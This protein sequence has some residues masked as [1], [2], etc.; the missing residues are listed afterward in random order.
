MA[1]PDSQAAEIS[2]LNSTIVRSLKSPGLK[3]V[4]AAAG[5][6]GRLSPDL[7]ARLAQRRFFTPPRAPLREAERLILE[8]G[9]QFRI[10]V[11]GRGVVGWRWGE[12]P[13][14]L[15]VHGWGGHAGQM[16]ELVA[17]LVRAGF[18]AVAIDLPGHGASAGSRSSI[19][20]F[21]R[22]IEAAVRYLGGIDVLLA[23]SFGAAG[24]TLALSRG[25]RLRRAVYLAPPAS[26]QRIW[27]RFRAG[28]GIS[29]PV[30][31]RLLRR[32]EL[33]LGVPLNGVEPVLLAPRLEVPLLILHD[34]GDRELPFSEGA[35]LAAAW[36]GAV[37][38]RLEGLGHLRLLKDAATVHEA[39][40]FVA[41]PA[42]RRP[43]I[44]PRAAE[45][46]ALALV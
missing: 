5:A 30:W 29:P 45:A 13:V 42:G 17:P 28:A 35:E 39:V 23:H 10:E 22:A 46:A 26:F 25:L 34:A 27:A 38:R 2:N 24:A 20:H 32:S 37:L 36:P 1:T 12:G 9:R 14:A 41:P 6:L 19:V 18:E 44:A 31:Q 4:R 21:A 3:L 33:W 11:E 43:R 15:L 8:G 7:A 40:S 16:T